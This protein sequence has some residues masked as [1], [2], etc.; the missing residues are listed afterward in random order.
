MWLLC[1]RRLC[2]VVDEHKNGCRMLAPF[3]KQ[4][5]TVYRTG[6]SGWLPASS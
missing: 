2:L 6:K 4:M 5:Q 3:A 1:S